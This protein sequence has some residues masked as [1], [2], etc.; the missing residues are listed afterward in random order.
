MGDK[1]Q[2]NIFE[3]FKLFI[4]LMMFVEVGAIL[5]NFT[6]SKT[7]FIYNALISTIGFT[8]FIIYSIKKKELKLKK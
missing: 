3:G 2:L 6:L 5:S 1:K 7:I 4:L 8:V